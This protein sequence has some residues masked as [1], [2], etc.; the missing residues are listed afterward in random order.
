MIEQFGCLHLGECH[1][2]LHQTSQPCLEA[3]LVKSKKK[4]ELGACITVEPRDHRQRPR[5]RTAHG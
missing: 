1:N 2:R 5:V 4:P 3:R